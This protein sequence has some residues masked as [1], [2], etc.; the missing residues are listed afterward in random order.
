MN[1]KITTNY[2]SVQPIQEKLFQ[3]I[4]SLAHL[5]IVSVF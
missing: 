2:F 1:N 3:N 4:S 5:N